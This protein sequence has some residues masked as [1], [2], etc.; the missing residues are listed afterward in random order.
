MKKII[1]IVGALLLVGCGPTQKDKNI[2]AVTCAVMQETRNMDAAIR[3]EKI[4][5]AREK[6]GGEPFL[7]GDWA[8][9][10]AFEWGLCVAL[11]LNDDYD[12]KL[13]RLKDAKA[14]Q[15]RIAAAKRAEKERIAATKPTV[16]EEL[17][18]IPDRA[19]KSP[20]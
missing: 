3:V 10:K 9:K 16:K 14:E 15:E 20:S 18:P 12:I 2:A 8:I 4:N 1:L 5:E 11:V 17:E 6:I 7:R 19:G 13:Q